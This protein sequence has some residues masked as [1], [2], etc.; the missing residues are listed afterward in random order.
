M[1]TELPTI[2][3]L[4]IAPDSRAVCT[5]RR[6][7]PIGSDVWQTLLLKI[8]FLANL[9]FNTVA[10]DLVFHSLILAC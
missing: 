4:V 2:Q 7:I 5:Y 9:V 6:S 8:R 3:V 1:P 10:P